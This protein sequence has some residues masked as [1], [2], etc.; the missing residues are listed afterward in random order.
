MLLCHREIPQTGSVDKVFQL[1]TFALPPSINVIQEWV[2]IQIVHRTY[3]TLLLSGFS[4]QIGL[5]IWNKSKT[6][7]SLT[8]DLHCKAT[9]TLFFT[10]ALK[11]YL[12]TSTFFQCIRIV[13]V[14]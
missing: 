3:V 2:I 12:K 4:P 14:V 9:A 1:I 11:S 13:V 5:A 7:I 10:R 6:A 8:F